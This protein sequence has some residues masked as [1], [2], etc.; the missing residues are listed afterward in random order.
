L[1]DQVL[2][3]LFDLMNAEQSVLRAF[4]KGSECY[5]GALLR[6]STLSSG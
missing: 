2:L 3:T 5:R 4:V 1:C 6:A